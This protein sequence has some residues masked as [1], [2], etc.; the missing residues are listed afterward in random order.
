M[1]T[2]DVFEQHVPFR[3]SRFISVISDHGI[4][5]NGKGLSIPSY[6]HWHM[7]LQNTGLKIVIIMR[8]YVSH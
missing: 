5:E 3:S 8:P 1:L 4:I 2:R 6:T 7:R